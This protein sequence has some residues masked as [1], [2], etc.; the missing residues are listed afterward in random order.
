MIVSGETVMSEMLAMLPGQKLFSKMSA[1]AETLLAE[2]KALAL[3]VADVRPLPRVR[4]LS[5]KHPQGEAYFEFAATMVQGMSKNFPAPLRC[6]EAVKNATTKK[7]D[8]GMVAE[9]E[10]FMQ[11]MMTPESR[12]LRHLFMAE[13]AASK[14]PDVPGDTPVRE[15]RTVGVIGAGT[16]GGGI[17]MNFLN[18]G[19]PVTILETKQEALDRGVA[20]IRKN[21]EAQVKRASSPSRSTSSAWRCSA[22]RST[23]AI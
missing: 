3:E 8:D 13:R 15:I 12:S 6:L 7:F 21:Y 17:S 9:R 4:D 2:A 11:L 14:I 5:C 1:S 23:M 20:T 19:I 18:A 10:A 22:P 16:M